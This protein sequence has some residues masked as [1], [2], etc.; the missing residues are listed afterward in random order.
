ML[1]G[2]RVQT[3]TWLGFFLDGFTGFCPLQPR[4]PRGGFD[5]VLGAAQPVR[6]APGTGSGHGLPALSR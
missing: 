1:K 3:R 2:L 5:P 4:T 6:A